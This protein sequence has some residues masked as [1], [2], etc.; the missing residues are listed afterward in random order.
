MTARDLDPVL[1][2]RI[3]QAVDR[4]LALSPEAQ[5]QALTALHAEDAN[6]ARHVSDWLGDIQASAG[7]LE[8]ETRRE[9]QRIGAWALRRPLGRGG[10]GE[11]WLAERADGAFRKFA[12]IKFLRLDRADAGRRLIQE[13]E[14]LARL[15]HPH[16]ARLIDAG[17]DARAGTYLITDWIDGRTLDRWLDE[18]CPDVS[19]CL[20]VFRRI[21]EAVAYAHRLLV[22]HRDIKPAN[23]MVDD[24]DRPYLLDFGIARVLADRDLASQTRDLAATP[25][26]A[27]PEQLQGGAIGTRVDVYGLGALLYRLLA[28]SDALPTSGLSLR[29]F[30][31]RVCDEMPEAPS[32]RAPSR[33][34]A[35]DLDAICLTAL[36]KSPEHRYASVDALLG[37]VQAY[38]DG[39]PVSARRAGAGYALG[40][41]IRRHRYA[42][43]GGALLLLAIVFGAAATWWQA[44]LAAREAARASAV[45]T[46]LMD[47]FGSI[48]PEQS[49]GNAVLAED[50]VREGEA[51]LQRGADLDPALRY[52]LLRLLARMR[53]DLRQYE[54][55]LRNQT[56][57]CALAATHFGDDSEQAT[58]CAVELA[59][60][61]RQNGELDQATRTLDP[62]IAMLERESEPDAMRLAFAYEVRFM[63]ERDLDHGAAA[64]TAI[65][66][67]IELARRAEPGLGTQTLHS[68]EQ[69]AMFLNAAGRLDEAEPLLVEILAFDQAHPE[70][71]ARTEQ[72]NTRW[73]LMVYYWSRERYRD[74]LAATA[75]LSEQTATDLGRNHAA[76]FRQQQMLAN[77]HARLGD[78]S[79]AI[80][81][82]D[83]ADAVDGIDA[84][85]KGYFRQM[86]WADQTIDLAALGR[87]DDSQV[88]AER[89]V[90]L[91][92]ARD[93]PA[94]PA[95]VACYGALYAA[96]LAARG[97]RVETW[98]QC[99]Q[100]RFA[101][102]NQAQQAGYRKFLLQAESVRLR[103]LGRQSE[104][105][106]RQREAIAASQPANGDTSHALERLQAGLAFALIDAGQF[107][108]AAT[109]LT[110]ARAKVSARMGPDHPSIAQMDAAI[111]ALPTALRGGVDG[112]ELAAASER[113]RARMG[114]APDRWRLW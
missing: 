31:R 69:Y 84:W 36:Q 71:R 63:I 107:E 51:R 32:A 60:S 82:R 40:K 20:A 25:N 7:F 4:L 47:L 104:A 12:A 15:D 50:L 72:I 92:D 66:R 101:A 55:R 1:F 37:D 76:F 17:E 14:V 103:V 22:I 46:F 109:L 58:V 95:F 97:D 10:M 11:V 113:F 64:E 62:V 93:L 102:L 49:K 52:E 73:N 65:R 5:A 39:R 100:Q 18:T 98:W 13:R 34:I 80:A 86:L 75:R 77:V 2:A 29:E 6:L 111:A 43:A 59:D 74:V 42:V 19:R 79:R 41:F 9:D 38:E 83:E 87:V 94:G 53:L 44:R 85:A 3:E 16:I 33:A 57:A 8:P 28:G 24:Q 54:A 61:L 81:I 91:T 30:V 56:G 106:A 89:A 110:D 27:A 99:L 90:A 105:I 88:L 67:S 112:A 70:T 68:L 26:Y 114:R 96:A 23:V 45:K 108:E 78:F 35:R 21:A 48:D